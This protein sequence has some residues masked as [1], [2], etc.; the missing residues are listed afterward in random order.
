MV[1]LDEVL[2]AAAAANQVTGALHNIAAPVDRDAT[3]D[4][5]NACH[6]AFLRCRCEARKR[7]TDK[8]IDAAQT[9]LSNLDALLA[10][11]QRANTR[12][13]EYLVVGDRAASILREALSVEAA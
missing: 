7:H 6:H 4:A 11:A 10:L 1:K 13:T 2:N 8:A 3:R 12:H 5:F 9:M